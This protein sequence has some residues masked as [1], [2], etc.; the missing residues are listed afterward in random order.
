[1][2]RG[3]A[4]R[5]VLAAALLTGGCTSLVGPVPSDGASIGMVNA[6]TVPV[7]VHVNGTWVGTFPA[8]SEA[9]QIVING[10]GGPPWDVRFETTV[11]QDTLIL[12]EFEVTPGMADGSFGSWSSSCG[13]FVAWF[14]SP[15]NDIPPLDPDA[16][17]PANPPCL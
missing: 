2:I 5:A 17:R 4:T 8:W 9:R 6:T 16:M 10:H 12:A 11:G 15:P 13:Q 1:V 14:G 7:A 3:L